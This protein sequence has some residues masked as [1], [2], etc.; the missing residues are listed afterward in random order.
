MRTLTVKIPEA[1]DATITAVAKRRR[2][3]RSVVVREAL[4]TVVD[5]EDVTMVEL[6]GTLAGW[7][8][9][10]ADLSTDPRHMPGFGT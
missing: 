7:F 6:T 3:T 8:D 10:E 4:S 9:G 5:A 2:T 1:L